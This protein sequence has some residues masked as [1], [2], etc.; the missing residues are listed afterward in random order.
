MRF[1]RLVTLIIGLIGASASLAA[2]SDVGIILIHGKWGS[3]SGGIAALTQ[4]LALKGF[5]ISTPTMPWSK[6]RNYD[7]DYSTALMEIEASAKVLR[8]QG[9]RKILV[10]GHSFGANSAI[11]YAASGREID[12]I[13]AIAPGHAP[14][15]MSFR[16]ALGS[17]VAKAKQMI[18]DG[19]GD[20]LDSFDDSNQGRIK[21]IRTTANIY[22]SYFDPEGMGA[23]PLS[24]ARFSR[25]VPFL[26]VI[27]SRDTLL[28]Q[29]E[30]YVFNRVPKHS[31]NKYLVIESDHM[32]TPTDAAGQIVEWI[33][34]LGY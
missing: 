17:S 10:G 27:G 25:P 15:L 34:S 9:A 14:D 33:S 30:G 12:G 18:S 7:A 29:G 16:N 22:F 6:Q 31:S 26:W 5:R 3:P 21:S 20:E 2:E 32:N 4:A 19:K 24:A 28:K 23:M 11:A 1:L 8:E 13:L